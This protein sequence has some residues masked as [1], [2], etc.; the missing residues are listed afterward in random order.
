MGDLSLLEFVELP[1]SVSNTLLDGK[2]LGGPTLVILTVADSVTFERCNT[3]LTETQQN[4]GN[5]CLGSEADVK[6]GEQ[7]VG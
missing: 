2:A 1:P 7:K 5:V 4:F 3:F 6:L